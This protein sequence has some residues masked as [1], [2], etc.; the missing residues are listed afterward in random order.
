MRTPFILRS[1]H[2]EHNSS[3]CRV[4]DNSDPSPSTNR[5]FQSQPGKGGDVVRIIM[6]EDAL[7][8]V[9]SAEMA[10]LLDVS[11]DRSRIVVNPCTC[12]C[13]LTETEEEIVD[14][15]E[16]ERAQQDVYWSS[17][18]QEEPELDR[19]FSDATEKGLVY[20]EQLDARQSAK[21][22]STKKRKPKTKPGKK[23]YVLQILWFFDLSYSS[24]LL[25]DGRDSKQ[26]LSSL[27]HLV[28][29]LCSG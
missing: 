22:R 25:L 16:G 1:S 8:R 21:T 14:E 24:A 9:P 2:W 4:G 10:F 23:V 12:P 13:C 3:S 17:G 26:L 27:F 20:A 29:A 5:S 15:V 19:Q 11:V 28:L 18:S 7:M 6:A